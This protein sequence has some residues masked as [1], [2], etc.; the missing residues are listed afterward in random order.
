MFFILGEIVLIDIICNAIRV[1]NA[2]ELFLLAL[3][4]GTCAG[5]VAL[6]DGGIFQLLD[7]ILQHHFTT[8][9]LFATANKL[10]N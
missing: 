6:V 4:N 2:L 8:S 1:N 10:A 9:T 3:G 5:R 7:A